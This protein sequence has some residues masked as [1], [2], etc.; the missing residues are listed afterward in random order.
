VI[1]GTFLQTFALCV[2][3]ALPPHWDSMSG[4][5]FKLVPLSSNSKEYTTVMSRFTATCQFNV[6]QVGS[7]FSFQHTQHAEILLVYCFFVLIYVVFG[8]Y[9]QLAVITQSGAYKF[10][11]KQRNL[12]YTLCHSWSASKIPLSTGS[13]RNKRRRSRIEWAPVSLPGNCFMEHREMC[14]TKFIKTGS[15]AAMLVDMVSSGKPATLN[16]PRNAV[17]RIGKI[18][19]NWS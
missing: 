7:L 15:I 14:A 3:T 11:L 4:Q 13:F 16:L 8:H 1:L 2:V 18:G 6:V 17:Y 10:L 5:L 12:C 9:H 19:C